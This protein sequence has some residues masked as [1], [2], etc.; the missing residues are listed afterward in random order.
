M[1]RRTLWNVTGPYKPTREVPRESFLTTGP[2]PVRAWRNP[3]RESITLGARVAISQPDG[4]RY[5]WRALSNPYW[6]H[7]ATGKTWAATA[8]VP[9][10]ARDHIERERWLM[11]DVC[12]EPEWYEWQA[13]G[14]MKPHPLQTVLRLP[15]E[16]VW[17]QQ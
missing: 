2:P 15:A 8:E 16:M 4:H 12:P 1:F 3:D 6:V 14:D 7:L 10:E 5:D 11:V 17:V 9:P 13:H